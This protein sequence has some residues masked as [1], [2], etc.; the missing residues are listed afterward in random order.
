MVVE[1]LFNV[2]KPWLREE[3][4]IELLNCRLRDVHGNP[5]TGIEGG[6]SALHLAARGHVV[7]LTTQECGQP[8]L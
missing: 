8:P 3:R 1:F 6:K 5:V 2:Q 7:L 4:V